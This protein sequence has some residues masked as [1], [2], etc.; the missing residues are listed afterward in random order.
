MPVRVISLS[1]ADWKNRW[2]KSRETVPLRYAGY[3]DL[4][5]TPEL[6]AIWNKD[7]LGLG[8][9]I[10]HSLIV[11]PLITNPLIANPLTFG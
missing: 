5:V 7:V 6:R 9:L 8:Y 3:L 10:P 2:Q 1:Y 4:N 11:N